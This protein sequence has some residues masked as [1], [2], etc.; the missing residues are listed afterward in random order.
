MTNPLRFENLQ[1]LLPQHSAP[2]PAHRTT[3]PN[4]PYRIQEAVRGAL[5]SFL[6]PSPSFL[7]SQRTL[8]QTQGHNN[9]HPLLGVE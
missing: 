9:V 3:G 7:P 5:G 8:Q 2:W 6:T 4:T 1:G